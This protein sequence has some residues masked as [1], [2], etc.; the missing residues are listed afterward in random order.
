V[1][2]RPLA[3]PVA[4]FLGLMLLSLS[5]SCLYPGYYRGYG[6]HGYHWRR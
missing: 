5:V 1:K 3:K 2:L 6:G 4:A